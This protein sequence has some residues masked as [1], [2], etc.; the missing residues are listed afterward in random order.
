MERELQQMTEGIVEYDKGCLEFSCQRIDISVLPDMI[1]EGSLCVKTSDATAIESEIVPSTYRLQ[2]NLRQMS[3]HEAEIVCTFDAH[4]MESGQI[5]NGNIMFISGAGEYRIPFEAQIEQDRLASSLGDIKNLFHFTNLAKSNWQEAVEMFYL[6]EFVKLFYNAERQYLQTY[7]GFSR[8]MGNEANVEEFL[9][10]VNKKTAVRYMIE[11]EQ[12]HVSDCFENN[13]FEI[14][15]SKSGWGYTYLVVETIGNIIHIDREVLVDEDFEGNVIHL[16]CKIMSD[17]LHAGINQDRVLIYN[18]YTHLEIPVIIEMPSKYTKKDRTYREKKNIL[19]L[20]S[21][22]EEYRLGK[23]SR[24]AWLRHTRRIVNNWMDLDESKLIPQLVHTQLLIKEGRHNEAEWYLKQLE[25][26]VHNNKTDVIPYAFYMYLTTLYRRDEAYL[27]LVRQQ[28]EEVHRVVPARWEITLMLLELDEHVNDNPVAKLEFLEREFNSGCSS[29]VIYLEALKTYL[30]RPASLRK[31][32][33]FEEQVL[34]YGVKNHAISIEL[35]DQILYLTER[36]KHFSVWLYKIL[37]AIYEQYEETQSLTALCG[38]LIKGNKIGTQ[39][40]D[41]YALGV[42][43]NIHVT[44]LYDYYM[45]SM[46]LHYKGKIPKMV[47]M[48][49]SY[50]TD[51]DY[52]HTAFLYSYII[53]HKAEYPEIVRSYQQHIQT[54]V[55]EQI[56]LGRIDPNLAYLYQEVLTKEMVQGE[57]AYALAP[58]LFTHI[59]RVDNDNITNVILNQNKILGESSYPVTNKMVYIPIYGREYKIFLQDKYG[60]RYTQS[61]GYHLETLMKP[62]KLIEYISDIVVDRIGI[63]LYLCE[64]NR[65]YVSVDADNVRRFQFLAESEQIDSEY[66][67]EIRTKLLHYYYDNDMISELDSY[68]EEIEPSHMDVEERAEF[69]KFLISRGM[70]DKAYDWALTYGMDKVKVKSLARLISKCIMSNHFTYDSFLVSEAFHIFQCNKYDENILSYLMKH[71]QGT[72]QQLRDIWKAAKSLDM[73]T[74]EIVERILEQMLTARSFVG[75]RTD[76]YMDYRRMDGCNQKL[77]YAFM[78]YS[79]YEYVVFDTLIDSRMIEV[80]ASRYILE[81]K[82][83]EPCKLAMLKYFSK[84]PDEFQNIARM[85]APKLI[86]QLMRDDIYFSFYQDL[87]AYV[88]ELDAFRNKRFVEYK[89]RPG[90]RVLIRYLFEGKADGE[91]YITE[92]MKEMY[93]GIHVKLFELFA[94]ERIQYYIIESDG[95]SEQIVCS[96]TLQNDG[97]LE[98]QGNS[99][100]HM[101]NDMILGMQHDDYQLVD[102]LIQEYEEKNYLTQQLFQILV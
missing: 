73:D 98:E 60:N 1:W 74:F 72:V 42:E 51:L 56:K 66:K 34:W 89:T 35:V 7:L 78:T 79:A 61:V 53:R 75:E 16:T 81:E 43:K 93:E 91:E 46:D 23:F 17:R 47:L 38:L 25:V 86:S 100:Y 41:W 68:L 45:M 50:Q 14:T 69:M 32:D 84:N 5:L 97:I 87:E 90:V 96:A 36:R 2:C 44:R 30:D 83:N 77:V 58:L 49:F 70:F 26:P 12:I 71:Y 9:I 18:A 10:E 15:V 54:H 57:V 27:D 88:P 13:T 99:R 48:Y 95:I 62:E 76:I 39:Y 6:P 22:Y 4:G 20:M 28:M 65:N 80:I 85:T 8:D 52:E 29:P 101:I 102:T 92:E 3:E 67:K 37:V 55:I 33:N 59:V 94:G 24:D 82:I 19:E 31:I 40:F 63:N 64:V 21:V 11:E